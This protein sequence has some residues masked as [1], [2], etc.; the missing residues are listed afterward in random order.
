MNIVNGLESQIQVNILVQKTYLVLSFV[1][2]IVVQFNH[3]IPMFIYPLIVQIKMSDEQLI[4]H[5]YGEV[6][7]VESKIKT[8]PKRIIRYFW[9]DTVKRASI[10]RNGKFDRKNIP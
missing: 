10:Y 6:C 8:K 9:T 3:K 7:R 5:I 2:N 4:K 1:Q